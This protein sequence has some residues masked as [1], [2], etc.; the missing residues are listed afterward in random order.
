ME[1]PIEGPFEGVIVPAGRPEAGLPVAYRG[2]QDRDRVAFA[3]LMAKRNRSPHTASRYRNDVT[4]W[5]ADADGVPIAG[6]PREGTS[7]FY[8]ADM[9]GLDVLTLLPAH[10]DAFMHW[11][12]LP[13]RV[14]RYEGKTSLSPSTRLGKLNAVSSFYRYCIANGTTALNPAEHVDGPR[15]DNRVSKT[16]GLDAGQLQKL[17]EIARQRGLREYALVQLLAGTGVRI[18][19]AV[20]ADT[21]DLRR[22]MGAW[23][24]YVIRKG[25]EDKAPV[26]VPDP[27][28]RALR[29]YLRGRR[30]PLFLDEDG[31]RMTRQAAA[32]RI[33][34]MGRKAVGD[35]KAKISP[36]S[37]RHTATT[38]LLDRG[39][40]LRSVQEFVGH[41][42]GE[43]TARYDR[44]NRARNNPAAAAM[45]EI[46]ADDLPEVD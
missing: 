14:V 30:G 25:Y 21:G 45:A 27:A 35:P 41:R 39:V 15:I 20:G 4:G 33:R 46:I 42:S 11:L 24:L 40:H 28:A 6:L 18:S 34:Q 9:K 31:K 12:K 13:D 38:L 10:I 2:P 1:H 3:W 44:A 32:N 23:Y 37:L 8:W 43:T 19:E 16:V 5:P 29:R 26:Q 17:R 36:H 22:E 7:F